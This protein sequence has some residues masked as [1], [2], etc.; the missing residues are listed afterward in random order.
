MAARRTSPH[1]LFGIA[2]FV[3]HGL[4]QLVRDI[5]QHPTQG[6]NVGDRTSAVSL[7]SRK[8]ASIVVT[9]R[10]AWLISCF[11]DKA[12]FFFSPLPCLTD[13]SLYAAS[14]RSLLRAVKFARLFSA[15]CSFAASTCPR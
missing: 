12:M 6:I 3:A 7:R 11:E 1:H 14:T 9:L 10:W 15:A 8:I 2:Q 4:L 13:A 5:N